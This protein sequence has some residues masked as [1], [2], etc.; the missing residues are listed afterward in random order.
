MANPQILKFNSHLHQRSRANSKVSISRP[1]RQL[2]IFKNPAD[3]NRMI[4][5]VGEETNE[6]ESREDLI[7]LDV[8]SQHSKARG[9]VKDDLIESENQ[10]ALRLDKQTSLFGLLILLMAA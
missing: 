1:S 7:S 6:A 8:E 5:W 10:M 3:I 4:S 2:S 9:W